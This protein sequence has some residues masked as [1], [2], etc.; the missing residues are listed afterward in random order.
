MSNSKLRAGSPR[1]L[2]AIASYGS[3][4]AALLK[5]IIGNYRSMSMDVQVVVL[6]EAPKELGD[7]VRV[8]V[9]LPSPNP[10]SL[11]FAHKSLFAA[12]LENFD[13]FVYSEDD[14]GVSEEN[15]RAFMRIT[16][17]LAD[18]EIAGYLRYE[19]DDGGSK[20]FPDM[21]GSFHWNASSVRQRGPYTVAEFTNEHAAFFILT[22]SQLRRA[23]ESGGFVREPYQGRYDMLC[24]AATDP[25]TSCGFRKVICISEIAPFLVHHLSN[26]YA[27]HVGLPLSLFTLQAEAL[28]GIRD[29][30]H[31]ASTLCRTEPE[32]MQ[33]SWSK[34]FYESASQGVLRKVPAHARTLLSIGCGWGATERALVERGVAVTALPLDSVIGAVAARNG[35]EM[36]YAS[37]DEGLRNLEG[38][39]FDAILIADLVQLLPEPAAVFNQCARLLRADG[40]LIVTGHNFNYLPVLLRMLAGTEP[41]RALR[42]YSQS[43][44]HRLGPAELRR[45]LRAAGLKLDTISWED[46]QAASEL[47]GAL[48]APR[49]SQK[50]LT[51]FWRALRASATRYGAGL[52]LSPKWTATARRA[53]VTTTSSEFNLLVKPHA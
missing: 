11:P 12:E 43:G 45:R 32:V 33:A 20:F 27:G 34:S 19:V 9:G 39:Q 8:A 28:L 30:T 17:H 5:Q 25:Y 37:L 6:S 40:S 4:N 49:S 47:S 1:V 21:F 36:I 14:I 16:P 46:R 35:I 23:I 41:Y 26:R 18:D 7:D 48:A 44:V 2:V 52:L 13:L 42:Q 3:R 15:I 29:K 24:T 53:P 22:Q 31:P 51:R 10:W 38:R 50:L